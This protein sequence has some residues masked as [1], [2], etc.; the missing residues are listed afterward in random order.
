MCIRDSAYT[1]ACNAS[2][3]DALSVGRVQTPT[4]A[5]VVERELAIRAF[6][7]ED[8]RE[9]VASFAPLGS[10]HPGAMAESG[11]AAS[12]ATEPPSPRYRGVWFRGERPD[13]KACLL[14]TS[15][16]V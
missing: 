13:P 16:C 9:V 10:G 11:D 3:E 4:L 12:P 7:P 6:A 14:Y 2:G 1:L 15:R 8:Y 5:V